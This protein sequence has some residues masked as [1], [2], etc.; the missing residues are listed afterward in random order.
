M[1]YTPTYIVDYIVKHT[2][3]KLVEG[4]TP[5]QVGGLTAG[6]Q[7]S[8]ARGARP[9]TVLDPACGSGSFLL[10]AYQFLLDWYRD[11][12]LSDGPKAHARGNNP[13]LFQDAS[14][15]WRLTTA[16][17]KRILLSHIH[18]VDIDSQAV[19]TTK[20]S[21]LLKVL[22]GESDE[23]IGS[24]LR[25]FHERA[26][27]DLA[28]NIKCGNSLIGPDFY[29][30]HQMTLFDEEGRLRINVF[31]W[32]AEFKDIMKAG[33]FDAVISNP[34]W[35]QKAVAEDDTVKQ[36]VRNRFRS[37]AGIYDLFRPFVEQGINLLND[38]GQF[39]MVLPDIVLLKDY[40]DTRRFLLDHLRLD[41]IDWWGMAFAD[42]VIDA[43]T[44]VGGR[45]RWRPHHSVHVAIHDG[46][47]GLCHEIPQA[48]F[49]DNPRFVFNLYLTPEK[50]RVIKHLETF[51][52]LSE[53][54]EI[55]EGVH[56]GNIRSELFVA[57]RV[58]DTCEELLFGR[59]EISPHYLS[60][61]GRFLRLAAVPAKKT[62]QRYANVGH[63]EWHRQPK[64]LVRRTG[65]YVLAAVDDAG[66]FA[67]NN[68]FLVF[69]HRDSALNLYGLCALLNSGFMTWY[70]RAIEP[71]KGR[72]FAE[73]K[74]KHLQTFPLPRDIGDVGACGKLNRLGLERAKSTGAAMR[75]AQSP[76]DHTRL[77]RMCA[78]L[79]QMID[80]AV[81]AAFEVRSIA[82]GSAGWL[83]RGG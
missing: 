80:S 44:I 57:D 79:D 59:D 7:P 3:G 47:Q 48:D 16:E 54:F 38:G 70:F 81:A 12:Y 28:G 9:L 77:E 50:R 14:G 19:E 37:T 10:G 2:V 62:R 27:P 69:P 8:K 51:P 60:W 46:E 63:I 68:F 65:D 58:D 4:K 17:R 52:V 31:D 15:H 25:L 56:S 36:Y 83:R 53:Y 24:N 71:R 82:G 40:P 78:A 64:V 34:P 49:A 55:H 1:Y 39:G 29:Q 20:L 66:R 21:L 11:Q 67:S 6:Y 13:R 61:N 74:I 5:R 35:G 33:G 45:E 26:L 73:L 76:T 22:E 18:G 23:A 43:V 75:K 32:S 42:A 41:A 72:V 30:Q